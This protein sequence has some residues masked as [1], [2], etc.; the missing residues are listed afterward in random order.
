MDSILAR[1]EVADYLNRNFTPV[2]VD[3][4]ADTPIE[5][6]DS[7][8]TEQQ[9]RKFLSIEGVPAYYFFDQKGRVIGALFSEM[10][11]LMFK[12]MLVYIRGNHF[13]RRTPWDQF[14][15]SPEADLDTVYGIF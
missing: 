11:L 5:V 1:P 3:I 15:Q 4:Y 2:K 10:D 14:I 12:R 7:T 8:M 6:R 9:F 13:L